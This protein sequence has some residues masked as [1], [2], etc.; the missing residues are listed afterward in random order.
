MSSSIKRVSCKKVQHMTKFSVT[1]TWHIWKLLS[2]RLN[3]VQT[4]KWVRGISFPEFKCQGLNLGFRLVMSFSSVVPAWGGPPHDM[5]RR[6]T[7]HKEARCFT[8][9]RP[10]FLFPEGRW[11]LNGTCTTALIGASI[12][13]AGLANSSV[14]TSFIH[15]DKGS[16][17]Y[18]YFFV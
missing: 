4:L 12:S 7:M 1:A 3:S 8:E 10:L 16:A 9:G 11:N 17:Y 15:P 13:T 5:H 18:A 2:L 14:W 6:W